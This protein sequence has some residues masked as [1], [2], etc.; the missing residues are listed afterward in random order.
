MKRTYILGSLAA[1]LAIAAIAGGCSKL[2]R[3]EVGETATPPAAPPQE[4]PAAPDTAAAEAT[5]PEP[6]ATVAGASNWIGKPLGDFLDSIAS[7][8]SYE[9]KTVGAGQTTEAPHS[10]LLQFENRS[11]SKAKLPDGDK[12]VI[13]DFKAHVMYIYRGQGNVIVKSPPGHGLSTTW[14]TDPNVSADKEATILREEVVD[15]YD[16]WVVKALSTDPDKE[17]WVDKKQGLV[18]QVKRSYGV[19]KYD[20]YRINEVPDSEFELPE[21]MEIEERESFEDLGRE[22]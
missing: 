18:R 10:M 11:A 22:R 15:D 9:M 14:I 2:P 5:A 12:W 13:I 6:P 20:Y 4:S 1:V 16:C 19:T 3:F 21:G 7:P 17:V 8:T